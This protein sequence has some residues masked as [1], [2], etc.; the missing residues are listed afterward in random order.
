MEKVELK[1]LSK[2]DRE[3]LKAQLAAEDK[4]E[5]DRIKNERETYKKLVDEGVTANFRDLKRLSDLLVAMKA[6]IFKSFDATLEMKATIYGVKESQQSHT[7]STSDGRYS[8]KLGH[9]IVDS[10]D[11][12]KSA[13]VAKVYEYLKTLSKDDNSAML[14]NSVLNLLKVDD[15]GNL[16]SNRVMELEKM[17]EESGDESFIDG[18]RIIKASHALVR[19]CQFLT[20]SYKDENG[21]ECVLPLSMSSAD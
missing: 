5:K 11:D 17:A 20:V 15:K 2:E 13:G 21:K 16:K 14:V 1:D 19:T 12:T 3:A 10:Y 4:A 8:I 18:I 9:R 6:R 7:F